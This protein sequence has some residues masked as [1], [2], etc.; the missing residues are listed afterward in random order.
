[1]NL[2]Y[3]G[4]GKIPVP[5]YRLQE[6]AET[7]RLEA[8]EKLSNGTVFRTNCSVMPSVQSQAEAQLSCLVARQTEALYQ[9]QCW[10]EENVSKNI[11]E[12]LRNVRKHSDGWWICF[13]VT[14]LAYSMKTIMQEASQTF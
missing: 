3:A 5:I 9:L 13:L 2:L 6:R 12:M 4:T 1:M 10:T 8:L 14:D 11:P 7:L